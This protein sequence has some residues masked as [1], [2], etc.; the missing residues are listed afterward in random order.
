MAQGFSTKSPKR[1]LINFL[2]ELN[3]EFIMDLL[4]VFLEKMSEEFPGI[5]PKESL[6]ELS[7]GI[8]YQFI[9]F[10]EVSL[11]N[12]ASDSFTD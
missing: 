6:K 5:L 9:G 1:L 8:P 2:N 3:K 4:D 10:I 7:T 11:E 12:N